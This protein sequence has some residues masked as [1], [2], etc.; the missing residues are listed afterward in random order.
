M[1][2][3]KIIQEEIDSFEW[4]EEIPTPKPI[5]KGKKYQ[6]PLCGDNKKKIPQVYQKLEE[7]YG[8]DPMF[9]IMDEIEVY[10]DEDS[11]GMIIYTEGVGRDGFPRKFEFNECH[12]LGE[13]PEYEVLEPDELM[14]FYSEYG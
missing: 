13:Y 14:K 5:D 8:N 4:M 9:H 6:I 3:K 2:I 1:N 7:L 11:N 12:N 10:M